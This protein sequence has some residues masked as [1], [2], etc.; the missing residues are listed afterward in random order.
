MLKISFII[1]DIKEGRVGDGSQ[2]VT[3]RLQYQA[4]CFTYPHQTGAA[5]HNVTPCEAQPNT[6]FNLIGVISRRIDS[7]DCDLLFL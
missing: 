7:Q 4:C 3:M 6:I 2:S 5:K 1:R